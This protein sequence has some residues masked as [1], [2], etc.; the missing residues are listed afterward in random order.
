MTQAMD[1]L[2]AEKPA[3]YIHCGDIC[4]PYLLDPLAGLPNAVV[5]GNNDWDHASLLDYAKPLGINFHYPIA[6]LTLDGKRIAVLHGDNH[7]LFNQL[8]QSQNYDYILFGH[9]HIRT[10]KI[11]G[12][13][14]LINP[15]ALHRAKPRTVAT[16]DTTT[17]NVRFFA[18]SE[19]L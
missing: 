19:R 16:L 13:T 7:Q 12:K 3:M 9:T 8:V 1:M 6:D 4:E 17:G 10:E 2:V 18:L 14:K 15:G 5:F 11:V